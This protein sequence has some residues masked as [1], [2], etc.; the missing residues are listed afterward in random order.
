MDEQNSKKQQYDQQSEQED[1]EQEDLDQQDY[2]QEDYEQEDFDQQDFK[3]QDFKQQ[4][5]KQFKQ[6]QQYQNKMNNENDNYIKDQMVRISE[7]RKEI[8]KNKTIEKSEKSFEEII[9]LIENNI[10]MY[11]E[12]IECC[13]NIINKTNEKTTS[14]KNIK[15]EKEILKKSLEDEKKNLDNTTKEYNIFQKEQKE[16]KRYI[17]ISKEDN[18]SKNSQDIY[19]SQ[20]GINYKF[21]KKVNLNNDITITNIKPISV[22][23]ID[24]FYQLLYYVIGNMVFCYDD[25]VSKTIETI[26]DFNRIGGLNDVPI[27]LT[28]E[29]VMSYLYD[30][31]DFLDPK[32]DIKETLPPTGYKKVSETELSNLESDIIN[33]KF[34]DIKNRLIKEENHIVIN[35]LVDK[36]KRNILIDYLLSIEKDASTYDKKI[37]NDT[38]THIIYVLNNFYNYLEKEIENEYKSKCFDYCENLFINLIKEPFDKEYIQQFSKDHRQTNDT[39]NSIYV[40]SRLKYITSFIPW[41]LQPLEKY[42]PDFYKMKNQNPNIKLNQKLKSFERVNLNIKDTIKNEKL[43]RYPYLLGYENDDFIKVISDVYKLKIYANVASMLLKINVKDPN[44]KNV[45]KNIESSET[46]MFLFLNPPNFQPKSYNE[47]NESVYNNF[48]NFDKIDG[49]KNTNNF[50]NDNFMI[51]YFPILDANIFKKKFDV[52]EQLKK[53]DNFKPTN[54]KNGSSNIPK[55]FCSKDEATFYYY[56]YNYELVQDKYNSNQDNDSVMKTKSNINKKNNDELVSKPISK[57]INNKKIKISCDLNKILENKLVIS[58]K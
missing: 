23:S 13:D 31:F 11:N 9:K 21:K 10:T 41:T 3:Q 7:Y 38:K 27:N 50:Y 24:Y 6:E 55:I 17:E 25:I 51:F 30:L 2:E 19:N 15:Q 22:H 42:I 4:N 28:T 16:I 54:L 57:N 58:F 44:E 14:Y 32:L 53:K 5:K 8:A 29:Y 49:Y 35:E 20:E 56:N 43:F 47:K 46:D 1:Y 40:L 12:A 39:N 45:E 33:K 37:K 36:E 48:G 34:E 18:D 26:N 52:A